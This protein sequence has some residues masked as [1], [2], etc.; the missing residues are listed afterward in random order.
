MSAA[1]AREFG[2]EVERFVPAAFNLLR[3]TLDTLPNPVL[4]QAEE[5]EKPGVDE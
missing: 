3:P 1:Y 2:P 5:D 4:T